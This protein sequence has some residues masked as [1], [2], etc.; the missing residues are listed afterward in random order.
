MKIIDT[1]PFSEPY[2]AEILLLK[3]QIEDSFVDEWI[4]VEKV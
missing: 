2:E 3:L 1:F 4:I